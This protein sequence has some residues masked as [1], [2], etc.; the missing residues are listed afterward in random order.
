MLSEAV[1]AGVDGFCLKTAPIEQLAE[2]VRITHRKGEYR[3]P[4]LAGLLEPVAAVG[5]I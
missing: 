2:A 3:D 4:A 5:L 1:I